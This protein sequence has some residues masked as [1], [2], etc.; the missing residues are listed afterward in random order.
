MLDLHRSRAGSLGPTGLGRTV[1]Y[2]LSVKLT[3]LYFDG[4]PHW[5]DADSLL[6]EIAKER[7]NVIVERRIVD[8]P[9]RA[10]EEQFR[11]SPTILVDGVDPFTD[12]DTPVGLSCR[13]FHTPA[14]P[15][16]VPT[17]AQLLE[18]IES[19]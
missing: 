9:E 14:G 12:L 13:I 17:K 19:R 2:A 5:A 15:A 4:C 10:V 8:T 6:A 3:L 16:G 18:A 7:D 11:G 1:P